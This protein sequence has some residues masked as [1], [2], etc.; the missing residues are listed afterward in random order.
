MA[1][2]SNGDGIPAPK[3]LSPASRR[4][5]EVEEVQAPVKRGFRPTP[6]RQIVIPSIE[7]AVIEVPLMGQTSLIV[8]AFGEKARR[9]ILEKQTK[10]PKGAREAKDPFQ[11]FVNSLYLMPGKSVPRGTLRP[12]QSWPY[13]SD[14][15]GFPASGFKNA[16][17]SACS[18][19]Q[20]VT[21]THVRGALHVLGDYIPLKYRKLVMREDVVRIGPFSSRVADIRFR[22]EFEDWEVVLKVRYNTRILSA[23]QIVNLFEHAGFHVGLGE[24]RPEKNGQFGT[25]A[26]KRT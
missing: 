21:K 3:V 19:I 14:T 6:I 1:R 5:P 26:V 13:K 20:G 24:W 23:E 18:F 11:D 9:Q 15:F 22:G 25:F 8:H 7:T 2:R 16:V 10:K 17:V 12:G 4:M